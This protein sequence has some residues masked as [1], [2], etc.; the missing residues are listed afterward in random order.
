M[1][2]V[3]WMVITIACSLASF[4]PQDCQAGPLNQTLYDRN[5]NHVDHPKRKHRQKQPEKK[6]VVNKAEK[7]DLAVAPKDAKTDIVPEVKQE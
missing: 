7:T 2:K 1:K 6:V 3:I 5:K 4:I